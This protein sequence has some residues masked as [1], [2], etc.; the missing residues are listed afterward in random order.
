MP[1]ALA[2]PSPMGFR[3]TQPG[4]A[5]T[6]PSTKAGWPGSDERQ[7]MLPKAKPELPR[8][9]AVTKTE[10]WAFFRLARTATPLVRTEKRVW[11]WEKYVFHSQSSPNEPS[12]VKTPR[13]NWRRL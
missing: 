9:A 4:A 7:T 12:R 3:G 5:V 13:I 8:L 11:E 10:S 6:L 2:T 1:S